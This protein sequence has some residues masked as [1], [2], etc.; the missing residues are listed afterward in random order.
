MLSKGSRAATASPAITSPTNCDSFSA[1]KERIET[2]GLARKFPHWQV[3]TLP[4]LADRDYHW[5][6]D[7]SAVLREHAVSLQNELQ[8]PRTIR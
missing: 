3:Y 5:G 2:A 8:A 4:A 7:L 6:Q 1:R